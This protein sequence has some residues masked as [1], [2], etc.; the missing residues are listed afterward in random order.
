MAQDFTNLINEGNLMKVKDYYHR[1]SHKPYISKKLHKFLTQAFIN[2]NVEI[3]DWL[4]SIKPDLKI[5]NIIYSLIN[6]P[7]ES[8]VETV[9]RFQKMRP[10][11]K[12][13]STF[14]TY[15]AE[16]NSKDPDNIYF[17][18][19]F[20][21]IYNSIKTDN[22]EYKIIKDDAQKI[23]R[24]N[25]SDFI[26]DFI[27]SHI[28]DF[29]NDTSFF[30]CICYRNQNS[31]IIKYLEKNFDIIAKYDYE[32][33]H[34]YDDEK[35]EEEAV[36][37]GDT[38]IEADEAVAVAVDEA[39]DEADK[40]DKADVNNDDSQ[41]DSESDLSES[42]AESEIETESDAESDVESEPEAEEDKISPYSDVLRFLNNNLEVLKYIYDKKPDFIKNDKMLFIHACESGHLE[43]AQWLYSINP[44]MHMRRFEYAFMWSCMYDMMDVVKW[45]YSVKPDINIIA[46]CG[47]HADMFE[48]PNIDGFTMACYNGYLDIAKWLYEINPEKI[49][50]GMMKYDTFA[51]VCSANKNDNPLDTLKWL[52][53]INP[54]S[55][56]SDAYRHALM[57]HNDIATWIREIKPDIEESFDFLDVF[58][59]ALE[60]SSQFEC[61]EYL[62]TKNPEFDITKNKHK[63]FYGAKRN[64]RGGVMK[65]LNTHFSDIYHINEDSSYHSY[66][67]PTFKKTKKIELDK[68][69]ECPICCD[70][71]SN[72]ITNCKHQYCKDCIMKHY[73][74]NN[75]DCPYCKQEIKKFY[76]IEPI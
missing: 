60:Y 44:D 69:I 65:F 13:N 26:F 73:Y 2:N 35:D 72:C 59:D 76:M 46:N 31:H 53:E 22:P 75:H 54:D 68:I 58:K 55:I 1:Y 14:L 7:K 63:I 24:Y 56:T 64:Y 70:N 57:T 39:A 43:I 61:L 11:V 42:E 33:E 6:P 12:F 18:D 4:L 45:I 71:T 29:F 25:S 32:R 3:V 38:A 74:E 52:Y 66:I 48:N 37:T 8:T 15:I 41:S 9:I 19:L 36:A 67:K 47:R 30:T 34:R 50:E 5:E 51:I 62:F 27:S 21:F 28:D 16:H 10:D 20:M 17:K 40:A 49:K 23:L